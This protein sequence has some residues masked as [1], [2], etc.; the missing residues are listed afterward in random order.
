MSLK[1]PQKKKTNKQN[2]TKTNKNKKKTN[3]QTKKQTNK[4]D[5]S[6]TRN[7]FS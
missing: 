2:K 6:L 5:M 1:Q 4:N 7:L 3:K